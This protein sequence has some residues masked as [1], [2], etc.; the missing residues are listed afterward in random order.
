VFITASDS[1]ARSTDAGENLSGQYH[2]SGPDA[3][4]LAMKDYGHLRAEH[5]E[6]VAAKVSF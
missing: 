6:A 1:D 4:A 2:D 3:G 5:S